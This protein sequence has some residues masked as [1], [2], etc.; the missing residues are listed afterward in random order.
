[1]E[2]T[3]LEKMEK[4]YSSKLNAVG[5]IKY[6]ILPFLIITLTGVGLS[7]L[8]DVQKYPDG[9]KPLIMVFLAVGAFMALMVFIGLL[10]QHLIIKKKGIFNCEATGEDWEDVRRYIEDAEAN[11]KVLIRTKWD[12]HNVMKYAGTKDYEV[13]L[14]EKYILFQNTVVPVEQIRWVVDKNVYEKLVL[15]LGN[16]DR[17]I[18]QETHSV[19]IYC[20][21]TNISVYAKDADEARQ[22][23]SEFNQYLPNFIGPYTEELE[24]MWVKNRNEFIELSKQKKKEYEENNTVL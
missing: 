19:A 15:R 6:C 13:M 3:Y 12:K 21:T 23:T 14:L 18:N 16:K 20:D 22:M 2:K 10:G 17:V 7:Q 24:Q 9:R 1:M 5:I 11:N 4:K 8:I